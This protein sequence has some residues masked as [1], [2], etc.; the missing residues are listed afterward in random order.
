M[1]TT[2]STFVHTTNLIEPQKRVF[3]KTALIEKTI[4]LKSRT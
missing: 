1:V 3:L 2:T 4:N